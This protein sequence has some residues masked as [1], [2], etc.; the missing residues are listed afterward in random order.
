MWTKLDLVLDEAKK[1]F[2]TGG[3]KL[4]ILLSDGEDSCYVEKKQN[5]DP[6]LGR[7]PKFS[8][9]KKLEGGTR[10]FQVVRQ[11]RRDGIIVNNLIAVANSLITRATPF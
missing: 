4:I 7:A 8:A 1:S 9:K 5:C 2:R 10:L 11:C 3:Q 6:A